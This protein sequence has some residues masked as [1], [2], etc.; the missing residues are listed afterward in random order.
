MYEFHQ[1]YVD[2]AWCDPLGRERRDVINPATEEPA[3]SIIFGNGDD[4][5]RA[6][7]AAKRAFDSYSHSS[8]DQ[9]IAFLEAIVAAYQS[10]EDELAEAVTAEMG[11]PLEAISRP[12]QVPAGLGHFAQMLDV[13]K[14]FAFDETLG[15]SRIVRE[16]VGVCALITPW[17]WPIN[18]IACKVAPALMAGCTVVLKP[19][20]VAPLSAHLLAEVIDAAGLPPGVFNMIDGDGQ[21]VGAALTAHRD[22]DMVSFTGS[23]RAGKAI[24]RVAADT[25]KRVALEL[26]GKSPNIILDDA[27]FATAVAGGVSHMMNNA[28]QSCNAPSR[29]LVPAARMSEAETIAKQVC[30][31]IAVGDPLDAANTMGPSTNGRQYEKVQSL[32][33]SGIDSGAALVCGGT[34]RPDGVERGFFS[35]PT[36]FSG[37]DN[38][39]QI[40]REE[41]FGPVLCILPY[42]NEEQAIEIANDTDYGLASY[43]SSTDIDRARRVGSRLRAGN[44]HINGAHG[45]TMLPFGGYKQSGIGREWGAYGLDEFLEVKSVHGYDGEIDNKR[46]E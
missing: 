11:A 30:E 32:I 24:S 18:Q 34:G 9:R 13:A 4:V 46:F 2:G 21:G 12:M 33:Q 10:R 42:E 20:E 22:V 26:G 37:V 31:G 16:P 6:V 23:T 1:H 29:M 15:N 25:V 40:A 17:N 35:K 27:D 28:G 44:V 3:G 5:D 36:V 43:V 38:A 14:N 45:G 39:M 7:A 19:S 8:V 41:I